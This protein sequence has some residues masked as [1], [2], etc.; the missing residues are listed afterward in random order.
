MHPNEQLLRQFYTALQNKDYEGIKAIYHPDIKFWDNAFGQLR[1]NRAGA[2]WHM[3]LSNVSE[4]SPLEFRFANI[5]AD[6]TQGSGELEAFYNFSLTGRAVHN[7]IRGTFQFQNG[8]IIRQR[9]EFNF[10]RWARQAFGLTGLLL[11]WTP[12][13]KQ[14]FQR[15]VNKRLD[16]FMA[17]HPEY[18]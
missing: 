8:K 17:K 14:K 3:L 5:K 18:I 2:M 4:E 9:D 10:W 13:F 12:F 15:E 7:K 11:G 16:K 1:G 6:D